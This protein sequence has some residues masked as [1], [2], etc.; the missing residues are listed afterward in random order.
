M[1]KISTVLLLGLLA[2]FLVSSAEATTT[3]DFSA[4]GGYARS[5]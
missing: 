3:W 1:R 5:L 2:L 4:C